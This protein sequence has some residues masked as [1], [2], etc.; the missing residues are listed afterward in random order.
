MLWRHLHQI[1]IIIHTEIIFHN[2]KEIKVLRC[3]G[4]QSDSTAHGIVDIL[5]RR[6]FGDRNSDDFAIRQ[7]NFEIDR[8]T[9]I[10]VLFQSVRQ[11]LLH[12]VAFRYYAHRADLLQILLQTASSRVELLLA[13]SATWNNRINSLYFVI[14]RRNKNN[15][16]LVYHEKK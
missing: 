13:Q 14:P 2:L 4:I 5:H 16:Y 6:C 11:K 3:F 10:T 12:S 9:L 7:Q 15:L 1:H 8:R